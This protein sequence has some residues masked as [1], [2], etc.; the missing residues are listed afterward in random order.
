VFIKNKQGKALI[1]LGSCLRDTFEI[2][3]T[4]KN[5]NFIMSK[6]TRDA[7]ALSREGNSPDHKLKS[8]NNN[9]VSKV[10]NIIF[11]NIDKLA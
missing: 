2:S 8:L 5:F 4:R 3:K 10:Q 6:R 11:K 7:K 1:D 9:L